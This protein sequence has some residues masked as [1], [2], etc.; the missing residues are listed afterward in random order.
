VTHQTVSLEGQMFFCASKN[1]N[2]K[3]NYYLQIEIRLCVIYQYYF[4]YHTF[5]LLNKL[6]PMGRY[7]DID[8][9]IASLLS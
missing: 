2:S 1:Y 9:I 8:F 6:I 5:M 3:P 4:V 7:T